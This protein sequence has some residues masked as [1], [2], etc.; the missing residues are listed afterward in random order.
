MS[1]GNGSNEEKR[2][3]V[4]E[5]GMLGLLHVAGAISEHGLS[6]AAFLGG[7]TITIMVLVMQAP[8]ETFEY[9]PL[10][11]VLYYPELLVIGLAIIGFL[12]IISS[13]GFSILGSLS[14]LKDSGFEIWKEVAD[15]LENGNMMWIPLLFLSLAFLGLCVFLPLLL[16]PFFDKGAIALAIIEGFC[17]Y[18]F[19]KTLRHS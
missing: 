7:L 15:L 9:K 4:E 5:K 1:S 13:M 18:A 2:D 12:F 17:I 14:S 6:V 8:S 19:L 16:L 3:I 11:S 10:S